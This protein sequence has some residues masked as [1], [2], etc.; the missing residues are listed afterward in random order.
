MTKK[1]HYSWVVVLL[2]VLS[3]CAGKKGSATL[4]KKTIV[5]SSPVVFMAKPR[6][7]KRQEV[8]PL[9]FNSQAPDFKLPCVD[10]KFYSLSDFDAS[11]VLVVIFTCNHCPTSQAY[12]DRIIQLAEDYKHESVQVVAISPNSINSLL[13]E[14]LGYSDL[15]DSFEEMKI[16]AHRKE[17]NFPYLYDGDTQEVSIKYGPK[18]T[19]HA[20]VFDQNRKLKYSG[21]IDAYEKPGIANANEIRSVIDAVL[22]DVEI[23][24]PCTKPFGCSVKWGWNKARTEKVN[25]DWKKMPVSLKTVDQSGIKKIMK[26]HTENLR[27][28]NVW[29][30]WCKPCA[31]DFPE[32]LNNYRMFISREFEFV[33]ISADQ[34]DHKPNALNFL[35]MNHAAV[36]NYIYSGKDFHQL[37]AAIDPEW[38]GALPYTALIEPEG[39]VVYKKTGSVDFHE[40]KRVILAHPIMAKANELNQ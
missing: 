16:R 32:F 40:L 3:A 11:K 5:E 17:F 1:R 8:F 36:Q 22:L 35:R 26:N 19:P 9:E 37:I 18:V 4:D 15:G 13:L 24:S 12:E 23:L 39:K 38:N 29:A 14:E 25:R 27:L 10:G 2:L 21:R 28:V 31:K 7:V 33:S 20:F 30:T 6:D 34:L